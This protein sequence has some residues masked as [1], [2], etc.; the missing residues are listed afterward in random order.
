MA[1]VVDRKDRGAWIC[2][3][4]D[5]GACGRAEGHC[6]AASAAAAKYRSGAGRA[7]DGEDRPGRSR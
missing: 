4:C 1:N 3:L 5:L 7:R 6:P 2:R